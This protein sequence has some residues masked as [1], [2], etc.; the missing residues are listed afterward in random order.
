[1]IKQLHLN[2]SLLFSE[3]GY[4]YEHDYDHDRQETA[5]AQFIMLPIQLSYRIG[6]LQIN[7]G[8]Y[9]EYGLGGKIE[10]GNRNNTY[11][12]F[13]YY[14]ALNYGIVAGAGVNMGK[15]FYLG[16]NYELGLS[17]YANRN[18]AISLGYNF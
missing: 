1:M 15:N 12:T 4:K 11:K 3:K 10:Y 2:T 13:N 14:D 7:A 17:N 6:M 9:L 16:A 18:I 8:P 5:K